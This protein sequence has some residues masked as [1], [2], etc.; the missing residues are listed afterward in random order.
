M[1]EYGNKIRSDVFLPLLYV[2]ARVCVRSRARVD[3]VCRRSYQLASRISSANDAFQRA[4]AD[5]LMRCM[6][7]S[8]SSHV[9]Y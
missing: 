2:R 1:Q 4:L 5:I 9:L 6:R 8:A 3:C 7:V